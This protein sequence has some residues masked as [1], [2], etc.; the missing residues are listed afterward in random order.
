MTDKNLIIIASQPR[1][2]STLLQALLSNNDKV[3]TVSEPWLLLPFLGFNNTDL[4]KAS[5][6]SNLALSGINDFKS[7]IG[8]IGFDK[9]LSQFLLNQY[10]K[11]L[12]ANETMVLDKTPRYYEILNEIIEYF[13]NCKII[14]LKRNPFAVLQSIIKTWNVKDINGLLDYKRDVLYAPFMLHE[15]AQKHKGNS[16]VRVVHYEDLVVDPELHI[17]TIYNWLSVEFNANV[18]QYA[19]NTKYK[20]GMGDPSGINKD[21]KPNV[22]SIDTWMHFSKDKYWGEFLNGYYKFL[23]PNFLNEYGNYSLEA[24]LNL[25]ESKK[26]KRFFEKSSWNFKEHEV[27]K[28]KLVK[29]SILRRLGFRKD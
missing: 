15:F 13:P 25:E 14:I 9:D 4:S 28:T 29:N 8:S 1:S 18:L 12:K 26:F 3:G 16:N 6:N 10:A 2:G 23:S 7:K 27:P 21:K 11:V 5:Y 22:N 20:G 19:K 17:K 24:H